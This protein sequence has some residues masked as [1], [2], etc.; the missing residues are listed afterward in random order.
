M[1]DINF[2]SRDLYGNVSFKWKTTSNSG[3]ENLLQKIAVSAFSQTIKNYFKTIYGL[4]LESAKKYN[5]TTI[6]TSDFQ[7]QVS[8]DLINLVKQLK[9]EDTL[10]DVPKADRLKDIS[11][12]KLFYDTKT[13][14]VVLTLSV[15]TNSSSQLLTLPVK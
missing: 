12:V 3:I 13:N 14:G 1:I 11:I 9:K 6:G 7:M 5:I 2:T 15:S 8:S 10:N 4:D